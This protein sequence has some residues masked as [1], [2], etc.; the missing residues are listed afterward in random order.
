MKENILDQ[1]KDLKSS[2]IKKTVDRRLN[3]FKQLGKKPS[4]EIFK[5]LCFCLLTANYTAEGGIR[6]QKEI[7]DGLI[8]LSELQLKQKLKQL[9]HRFPNKRGEYI[10]LAQSQQKKLI[11]MLKS[12][13]PYMAREWLVKNVKGLGYKESSHF[14]RNIGYTNLAIIDFHIVDIL[15][16]NKL[17]EKPKTITPKI[18]LEIE[19]TLQE[20]GKELNMNMAELDLYL[21]YLETGKILK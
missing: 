9:K 3:E 6:I 21:W 16:K 15:V 12:K 20:L 2:E 11:E 7:D 10:F 14:L 18:Y 5:E 8:Y 13:T 4:K 1:V 17:V 19:Q